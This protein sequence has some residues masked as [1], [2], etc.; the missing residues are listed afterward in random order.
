MSLFLFFYFFIFFC[1]F[2]YFTFFPILIFDFIFILNFTFIFALFIYFLF[3]LILSLFSFIYIFTMA[4]MDH[5]RADFVNYNYIFEAPLLCNE[6][7]TV[8]YDLIYYLPKGKADLYTI[9]FFSNCAVY[10]NEFL[11]FSNN[12]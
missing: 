2:V 5:H 1:Y 10:Y 9:H 4:A 12:Y 6:H 8:N 11:I 3:L 7:W